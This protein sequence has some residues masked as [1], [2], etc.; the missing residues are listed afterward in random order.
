MKTQVTGDEKMKMPEE[1]SSE[2]RQ[3]GEVGVVDHRQ[4]LNAERCL[5]E[6]A[7]VEEAS[8]M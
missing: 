8:Q 5:L 2:A 6:L 7:Q 3:Q 1:I 4:M